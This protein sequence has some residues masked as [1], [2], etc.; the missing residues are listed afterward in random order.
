MLS[1]ENALYSKHNIVWA[2]L[3]LPNIMKPEL[4]KT[5]RGFCGQIRPKSIRLSQIEGS[6][7]DIR[8]ENNLSTGLLQYCILSK[9][10]LFLNAEQILFT[11]SLFLTLGADWVGIDVAD[12]FGGLNCIIQPFSSNFMHNTLFVAV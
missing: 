11:L 12:K 6:I 7:L 5:G 10:H 1:R 2:V 8:R 3:I 9:G 4:L